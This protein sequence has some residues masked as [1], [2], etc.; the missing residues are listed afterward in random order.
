MEREE[1]WKESL[2]WMRA[3]ALRENSLPGLPPC[4]SFNED[5]LKADAQDKHALLPVRPLALRMYHEKETAWL[6][7]DVASREAAEN[8]TRHL[9]QE[10]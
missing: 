3:R 5:A 10:T 9:W 7:S 4:P 2:E 1:D 8:S 6:C